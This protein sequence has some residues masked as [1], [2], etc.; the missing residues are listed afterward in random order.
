MQQI[1]HSIERYLTAMDS[2]DRAMP[3]VAVPKAERLM[4]KIETL[5]N[6]CRSLRYRGAATP[7]PRQKNFSD[8]PRYPLDVSWWSRQWGCWL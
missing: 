7:K 6:R 1:E 8:G 2:A 4:E 3:E 5:N